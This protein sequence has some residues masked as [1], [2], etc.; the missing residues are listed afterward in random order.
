[1]SVAVTSGVMVL[2]VQTVAECAGVG[3]LPVH[4]GDI[5]AFI[6]LQQLRGC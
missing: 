2:F 1:M 3:E 5:Y 4:T 6:V